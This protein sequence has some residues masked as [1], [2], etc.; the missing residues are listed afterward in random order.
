[1]S[2]PLFKDFNKVALDILDE[3]F[4][5]KYTLKVKSKAPKGVGLTTTTDYTCNGGKASLGGKVSLKWAH[6]SGFA[7]DKLEMKNSGNV[8]VE[9]SL[10]GVAPGL[11]FEFKGDDSNKGD[12]GAIYKHDLATAAVEFDVAEFSSIKGSVLAGQG[13]FA[14]GASASVSL[15]D[16]V[17]VKSMDF[18]GSYSVA[19]EMFAGL[20]VTNK[21]KNYALSLAYLAGGKYSLAGVF[22]FAPEKSTTSLRIGGSYKCNPDTT[23]KGKVD[24]NGKVAVSVKQMLS[25]NCSVNTSVEVPSSDLSAYKLGVAAT[26]G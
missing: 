7:I 16:K 12:L 15:G 17:D 25:S 22:N 13:P 11:K 23:I 14:G 18:C 19:K 1:M 8:V 9:T 21:F 10:T 6:P 26:L 5:Y 4:D 2:L 24:C 3:D 20:H